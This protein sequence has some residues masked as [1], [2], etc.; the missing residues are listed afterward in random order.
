MH[1]SFRGFHEKNHYFR[2]FLCVTYDSLGGFATETEEIP[3]HELE[4]FS[5]AKEGDYAKL[6]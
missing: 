3:S 2:T 4:T 1:L 5:D 6:I